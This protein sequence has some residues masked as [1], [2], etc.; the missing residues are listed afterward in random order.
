MPATLTIH[1]ETASGAEELKQVVHRGLR[2]YLTLLRLK[3]RSLVQ[4]R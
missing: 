2:R 3:L 4:R 1:D